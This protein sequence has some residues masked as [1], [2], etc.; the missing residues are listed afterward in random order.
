MNSV[1][2]IKILHACGAQRN[3]LHKKGRPWATFKIRYLLAK[4]VRVLSLLTTT[5]LNYACSI[6]AA[7]ALW[8]TFKV[9]QF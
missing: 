3:T 5:S 8:L 9:S 1:L 4:L 6:D 2:N 7:L